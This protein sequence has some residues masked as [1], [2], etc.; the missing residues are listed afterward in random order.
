VHAV[1]VSRLPVSRLPVSRLEPVIG[2]AR[3]A[4]LADAAGGSGRAHRLERQFDRA[5]KR[6]CMDGRRGSFAGPGGTVAPTGGVGR[7]QGW[8]VDAEPSALP[9]LD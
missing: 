3:Y 7:R 2:A 6:Y 4:E 9:C 8:V 5:A 1:E